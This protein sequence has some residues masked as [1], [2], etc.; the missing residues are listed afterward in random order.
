[1]HSPNFWVS[2]CKLAQMVFEECFGLNNVKKLALMVAQS[3]LSV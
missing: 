1:M 3:P 2:P